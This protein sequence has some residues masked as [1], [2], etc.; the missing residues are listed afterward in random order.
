MLGAPKKGPPSLRMAGLYVLISKKRFGGIR[1][2]LSWNYVK[3]PIATA[4]AKEKLTGLDRKRQLR[5][6][7]YSALGRCA[8]SAGTNLVY[9]FSRLREASNHEHFGIAFGLPD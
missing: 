1:T 6:Q 5:N 9:A 2:V 8:K 4:V 7:R 3:I